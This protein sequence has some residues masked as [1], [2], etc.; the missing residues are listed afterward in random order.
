MRLGEL[1][2]R[3]RRGKFPGL[4][5]A[6]T[7]HRRRGGIAPEP[8]GRAGNRPGPVR[9]RHAAQRAIGPASLS[10]DAAAE[11]GVAGAAAEVRQGRSHRIAR[12]VD[13]AARQGRDASRSAIRA[14][15][16]PR[17][18]PRSTAWKPASISPCSTR[19]IEVAVLRGVRGRA[20]EIQGPARV[21]RRHQPHAPLSR[22]DS[23][24][25]VSGARPRLREQ[26]LS[27][28]G[29]SRRC[30]A[31][32]VRR[33]D[34]REAV[35]RG[36]GD[37]SPSAATARFCWRSTTCWPRGRVHDAAGAQG[38]HHS[39]RR[40]HAAAALRRRPHRPAGDPVRAAAGVRQ[41]GGAADLR[42]DR[43]QPAAWTRRS[44]AW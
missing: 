22:P 36:G 4:V 18:R 28:P 32:R 34:H 12:R 31:G 25:L 9:F 3:R 17:I 38:G 1:V 14:S 2:G 43:R 21:R 11:A 42:R 33:P 35:D 19:S 30:A 44:S 29:R 37:P 20:S 15:S 7:G 41:P 26:A 5:P 6:A 13:R 40:Q 8:E 16:M 39:R 24:P 10:G 27:R 23:V